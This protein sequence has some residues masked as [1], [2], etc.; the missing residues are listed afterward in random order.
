MARLWKLE[1]ACTN[2]A[3]FVLSH[4]VRLKYSIARANRFAERSGPTK[5]GPKCPESSPFI[6]TNSSMSR[7]LGGKPN[8]SPLT[9]PPATLVILRQ[10]HLHCPQA[11]RPAKAEDPPLTKH[12][13]RSLRSW[14]P[15]HSTVPLVPSW[16]RLPRSCVRILLTHNVYWVDT[17][18]THI[19]TK[20]DIDSF[21]TRASELVIS[22][23][24]LFII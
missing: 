17:R 11:D 18:G 22:N 10:V 19:K 4:N 23:Y 14:T 13:T 24:Y 21:H 7:R 6:I 5:P 2:K 20:S 8:H 12:T 9:T 16:R 1:Q 3:K 15:T